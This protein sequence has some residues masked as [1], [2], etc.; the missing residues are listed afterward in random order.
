MKNT[1]LYEV[2]YKKDGKQDYIQVYADSPADSYVQASRLL[3]AI[4]VISTS[5]I[6]N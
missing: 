3:G 1:Y 4:V 6:G 2:T 5:R